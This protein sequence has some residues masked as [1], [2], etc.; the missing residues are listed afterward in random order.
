MTPLRSFPGLA[1]VLLVVA[2]VPSA[3]A[4]LIHRY[5]F[6]DGAKDGAGSVDGRLLGAGAT[7]TGGE[8]VLKNER[9][10]YGD[11]VACL[12]FAGP[13][14]P[15][16]GTSASLAVWFTAKSI[17][18]FARVLNFGD[19]EGT[20]GKQFLY[21]TPC[22]EEGLARVAIT[23]TD[24]TAKTYIDFDALDDGRPHL[25]V[26][27]VDGAAQSLRVFVDGKEPRP[28]Q[29]LGD[30]TLDKVRPV[31]NWIGRSSFAADPGLSAAITELRVY[32]QALTLAES[33]ALHQAGPDALPVSVAV[34][35]DVTGTWDL[36]VETSAGPGHPVFI[37]K[38]EG[39]KLSGNYR[40]A[41]GAAPVTGTLR[42]TAITFSV[43]VK[44]GN[45]DAV[46][47]YAGTVEGAA[48]KGRVTIGSFGE[49]TFTGTK[50]A[51]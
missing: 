46:I 8:L 9:S 30:N 28:A 47:E 19:S 26:I 32:D 11:K 49:G 1:A 6:T 7:I 50:Q 2:G 35:T 3:R 31:Q 29:P 15:A 14:L 43:K 33:A 13:V 12:E 4:T 38:Q 41:F 10:A 5:S 36:A 22:T 16:G 21:F 51:K 18:G 23:A 17:G 25:V 34:A 37:F 48:M 45:Q 42:G 20:E 40:G 44:A 39:E 27:V 24:A